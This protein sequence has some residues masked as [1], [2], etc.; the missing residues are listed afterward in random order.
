MLEKLDTLIAFAV[1]M[2]GVSLIIT[3]LTQMVSGLFGLRGS[4]LLWGVESLL[5]ELD[6]KLDSR[7]QAAR[8]GVHQLAQEILTNE[9]ISDSTFSRSGEMW[10]VGPIIKLL[11]K[12]PGVKR[13]IQRWQY[14]TAIR[15]EELARM[16]DKKVV[17]L[18]AAAAAAAGA[19]A[20]AGAPPPTALAAAA[21][22]DLLN[23]PDPETARKLETLK[24]TLTTFADT[25]PLKAA[26]PPNIAIQLDKVF[27]QATD[28]AQR[29][30]TK[31]ETS[32]NTIMDRVSQRF[33]MEM[34][35]WTVVFA[36]VLAFGVHLDSFRLL[37]QL[38]TN[39]EMRTALVNMRDN[40]LTEA[41]TV[42]PSQSTTATSEVPVSA[43]ILN[44]A[45]D[46]L[47][48]GQ[49]ALANVGP[50]PSDTT[51]VA[52]A[53]TWL[54]K[55]PGGAA[56]GDAY[57]QLVVSVLRAHA[58]DIN[59][60]LEQAGFQLIPSP[61]PG[62]LHY[63]GKRNVLGTLIAAALLSLGA[64]FWYNALKNLSNLRTVVASRQ[65]QPQS[66]T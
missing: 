62:L 28:A 17:S 23:A 10:L 61:Y 40:M 64:P 11:C 59:D 50:V 51:T 54:V 13:L 30:L 7:L 43:K 2:L 18:S 65:E 44:E 45:L 25:G 66:A 55:Q 48:H 8:S 20:G 6:P 53:V 46:R 31:L 16:L 19:G 4:N 3:I 41:N 34:R 56:Q 21:L 58:N 39:P 9:S 47:K 27:Q 42:L 14:A 5:K 32:F 36:F 12:I 52:D 60:R 29:S 24:K 33:A 57:R 37:D 49:A 38:S 35:L 63:Q 26:V 15:P 1:V 22:T